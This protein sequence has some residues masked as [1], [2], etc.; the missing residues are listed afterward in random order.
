MTASDSV[1][2]RASPVSLP[3]RHSSSGIRSPSIIEHGLIEVSEHDADISRQFRGEAR[4]TA[5]ESLAKASQV[6]GLNAE[7]IERNSH[8]EPIGGGIVV[9]QCNACPSRDLALKDP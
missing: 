5:P 7:I 2:H 4:V 9:Q 1:I 8:L 3:W 6:D